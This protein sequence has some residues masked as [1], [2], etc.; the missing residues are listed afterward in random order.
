M[1]QYT[2]D[3]LSDAALLRQLSEMVA[4]DRATTADLLVHIAEVDE[5]RLYAGAGYPSMFAYCVEDLHLSEVSAGKRI[6]AARA[7]RK[8][9]ALLRAMEDG[10]IHLTAICLLAPHVTE[11][12]IESLI[13]AATHKGKTEIEEWLVV[14][15]M[16]PP[17][18]LQPCSI[19]P[20]AVRAPENGREVEPSIFASAETTPPAQTGHDLD[21]V[22][23]SPH[24]SGAGEVT[25]CDDSSAT[26]HAS[27]EHYR[28]QVTIPKGTHDKLRHA[29]ALLSHAVAPGDV[30]QV[31]DRA[32][33]L[34][35]RR[36]ESRRFGIPG[37]RHVPEGH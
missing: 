30:A 24:L 16:R 20:V 6:H 19:K 3:H 7:A 11:E 35:I 32:L 23:V 15:A 21:H 4:R 12:N 13:A 27:P 17:V 25:H 33:D 36:L 2:L 9:P 29:Q 14:H 5:R 37:R 10:R 34:L 18:R 26:P 22:E 1:R 8:F 31:L 28:M